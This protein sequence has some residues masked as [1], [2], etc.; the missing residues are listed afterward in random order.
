MKNKIKNIKKYILTAFAVVVGVFANNEISE[1]SLI[2][3]SYAETT[4]LDQY[5][6]LDIDVSGTGDQIKIDDKNVK[7]VSHTL[8]SIIKFIKWIALAGTF[9]LLGVFIVN[10]IRM[11]AAGTNVQNRAAAQQG[12]IWSG[13]SAAVLS[14]ATSVFFFLQGIL[15]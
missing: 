13:V 8:E 14:I 2:E 15:Q 6:D 9:L 4:A 12:L 7:D 10:L 3:T 5:L 11:G 1:G